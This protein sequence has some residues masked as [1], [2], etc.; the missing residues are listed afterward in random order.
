MGEKKIPFA[1]IPDEVYLKTMRSVGKRA[2]QS[3]TQN[4]HSEMDLLKL[5]V[6]IGLA[7]DFTDAKITLV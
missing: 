3:T 4:T 2:E 7:L 5:I 1:W 6:L